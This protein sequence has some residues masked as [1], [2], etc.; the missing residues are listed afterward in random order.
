[1]AAGQV[2]FPLPLAIRNGARLNPQVVIVLPNLE[3]L[4][5]PRQR[6]TLSPLYAAIGPAESSHRV[7]STKVS[8]KHGLRWTTGRG[9]RY[10]PE[11]Y[12]DELTV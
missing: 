12:A 11:M 7:L 1:M 9:E 10:L 3:S 2:S 4:E 8:A 5:V 6:V